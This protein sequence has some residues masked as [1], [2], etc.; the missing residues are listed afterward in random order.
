MDNLTK[1]NPCAK[2]QTCPA[3]ATKRM[4]TSG[5]F[6]SITWTSFKTYP[7][8]HLMKKTEREKCYRFYI[9][10]EQVQ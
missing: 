2:Q 5:S 1:Q 10:L 9:A 8:S 6:Q 4:A 7:T 3:C